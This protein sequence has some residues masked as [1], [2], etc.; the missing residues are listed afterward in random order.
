MFGLSLDGTI[1]RVLR[2]ATL[3]ALGLKILTIRFF[4]IIPGH[5][6]GSLLDGGLL[7]SSLLD[8]LLDRRYDRSLGTGVFG[9]FTR[10]RASILSGILDGDLDSVLASNLDNFLNSNL[11]SVFGSV[12]DSILILGLGLYASNNR[13][14]LL[15]TV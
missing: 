12:L 2:I 6:A 11:D 7:N 13:F 9:F 1:F 8:S 10:P 3:A 4:I 5:T 15:L 14:A